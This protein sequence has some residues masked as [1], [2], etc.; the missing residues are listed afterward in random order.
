M[1]F[2]CLGLCLIASKTVYEALAFIPLSVLGYAIDNNLMGAHGW[3]HVRVLAQKTSDDK[4]LDKTRRRVGLMEKAHKMRMKPK[5]QGSPEDILSVDL[6]GVEK[7]PA[8]D[9]MDD[10]E[11]LY[12]DF[13][14]RYTRL[15][16]EFL[17]THCASV[18]FPQTYSIQTAQ[19][20]NFV[21]PNHHYSLKIENE[22]PEK[23]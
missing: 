12:P 16:W 6:M 21:A 8:V 1:L 22:T 20:K 2:F 10:E 3:S 11:E 18:S 9:G 15:K 4:M 23:A 13:I 17:R 19:G 14:K 7:G 5:T